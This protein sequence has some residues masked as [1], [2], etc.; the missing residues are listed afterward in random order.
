MPFS[1]RSIRLPG[2]DYTQ[3]G[4]YFVTICTQ[5]RLPLFGEVSG[6][7]M[8]LDQIGQIVST[9]WAALPAAFPYITL[10]DWVVMPNHFHA[11]VIING[12]KG[13]ASAGRM[14]DDPMGFAA[15]ASPLQDARP[16]APTL[17][18]PNGTNPGS[19][20]AFLQN[21]KSVSTRKINT[22]RGTP[23]LRLWQ[24]NYYEHILRSDD[25]LNRV[26][27]Y[28]RENPISWVFDRENLAYQGPKP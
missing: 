11:I 20:G 9:C 13:E 23:G 3:S 7:I 17:N 28:I 15:D 1:R 8:R 18:R 22:L 14:N 19:L 27:T 4:A 25:D 21:F 5:D 6:G 12:G 26:R 24:R 2:Y 16:Y 10:A